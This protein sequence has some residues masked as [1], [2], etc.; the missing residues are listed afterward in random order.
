MNQDL[1][2]SK[3]ECDWKDGPFGDLVLLCTI[4]LDEAILFHLNYSTHNSGAKKEKE[5][6]A[7]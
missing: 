4:I 1:S 2:V 5:R 6:N 7:I 3:C